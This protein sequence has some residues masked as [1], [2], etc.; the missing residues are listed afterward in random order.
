MEILL[1]AARMVWSTGASRDSSPC[2][3]LGFL[4]SM[5]LWIN[6]LQKKGEGGVTYK[7]NYVLLQL[8]ARV[9]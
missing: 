1:T 2:R 7:G 3:M 8:K 4:I 9:A 6:V 5:V